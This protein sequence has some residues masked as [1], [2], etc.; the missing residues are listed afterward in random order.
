MAVNGNLTVYNMLLITHRDNYLA[1]YQ[2]VDEVREE[3]LRR[4]EHMT[5]LEKGVTY[6]EDRKKDMQGCKYLPSPQPL[7]SIFVMALHIDRLNRQ[8]EYDR[9]RRMQSNR[10]AKGVIGT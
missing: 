10:K 3:R 2:G 7:S 9:I 4:R 8:S 1:E 5:D 6:L